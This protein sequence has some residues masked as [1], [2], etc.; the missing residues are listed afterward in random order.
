MGRSISVASIRNRMRTATSE[1]QETG[2]AVSLQEGYHVFLPYFGGKDDHAALM[3]VIQLLQCPDVKAT[4][5]KLR[6]AGD[7]T[8]GILSPHTVPSKDVGPSSEEIDTRKSSSPLSAAMSSAMAKVH[9]PHSSEYA[10]L[11]E[12]DDPETL[13]D[14]AQYSNLMCSIPSDVKTRLTGL[15]LRS[16]HPTPA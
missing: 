2:L 15:H 3:L 8:S 10:S 5:L 13:P 11:P 7:E 1:I 4:V 16:S 6:Y 9:F 12:K 14:H